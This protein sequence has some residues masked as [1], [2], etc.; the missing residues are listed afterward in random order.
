[1]QTVAGR[2]VFNQYFVEKGCL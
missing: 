2:K 1:M